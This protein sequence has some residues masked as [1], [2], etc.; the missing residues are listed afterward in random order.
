MNSFYRAKS[1]ELF[2]EFTRYLIHHPEFVEHIPEGAQVALL[3]H[4]VP[5]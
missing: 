2:M 5:Q 4:R 3:V 1:N